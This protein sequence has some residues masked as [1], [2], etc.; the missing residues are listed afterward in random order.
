MA[1]ATM[2]PNEAMLTAAAPGVAVA[3]AEPEAGAELAPVPVLEGLVVRTVLFVK[4]AVVLTTG[5]PVMTGTEGAI[6]VTGGLTTGGLTTGGLT[7][8][9]LTTGGLTTGGLTPGMLGATPLVGPPGTTGVVAGTEAS[10]MLVGTEAVTG[11]AWIW[12]SEIW[13]M[14]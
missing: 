3:G 9:G 14:T 11:G 1:A 5:G 4:M 13:E 8:G 10:G 7:T 6:G 2:P 12:P